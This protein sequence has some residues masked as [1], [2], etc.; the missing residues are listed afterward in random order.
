MFILYDYILILL[1]SFL[2][3]THVGDICKSH[4]LFVYFQ[5][6]EKKKTNLEL[7]YIIPV[8]KKLEAGRYM[9]SYVKE[10]KPDEDGKIEVRNHN[11]KISTWKFRRTT[12]VQNY[13]PV[14]NPLIRKI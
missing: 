2:P 14:K 1:F 6:M 7:G 13:T 8:Q 12:I 9:V 10:F 11:L 3:S 4:K 5:T